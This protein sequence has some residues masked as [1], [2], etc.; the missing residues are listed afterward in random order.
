MKKVATP[1]YLTPD[2]KESAST[3]AQQRGLSLSAM[4]SM[5]IAGAVNEAKEAGEIKS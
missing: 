1:I 4:V 5:L 2:I 3:L